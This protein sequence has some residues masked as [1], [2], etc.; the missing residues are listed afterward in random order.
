MT[1]YGF[2]LPD[3]RH[4]FFTKNE[5]IVKV[6]IVRHWY[7]VE[8]DEPNFKVSFDII[9]GETTTCLPIGTR[10]GQAI[11]IAHQLYEEDEELTC[12]ND[13]VEAEYAAER[14][15]GA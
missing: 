14:R 12:A 15:M 11:D 5:Q 9:C 10:E 2:E 1:D 13:E 4:T 8:D 3:T 6:V 7:Q